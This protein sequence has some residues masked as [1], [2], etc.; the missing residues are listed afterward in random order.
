MSQ[1]VEVGNYEKKVVSKLNNRLYSKDGEILEDNQHQSHIGWSGVG[2]F[3]D[4][5][6]NNYDIKEKE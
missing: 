2:L 6:E 4:W 1:G 5:L 3:I